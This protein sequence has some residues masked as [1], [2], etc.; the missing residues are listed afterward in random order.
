MVP[1]VAEIMLNVPVKSS[2]SRRLFAATLASLS[3]GV[4]GTQPHSTYAAPLEPNSRDLSSV[5]TAGAVADVVPVAPVEAPAEAP[6]EKARPDKSSD[7]GFTTEDFINPD[8]KKSTPQGSIIPDKTTLKVEIN[9]PQLTDAVDKFV[10]YPYAMP[11][12]KRKGNAYGPMP[13]TRRGIR[14]QIMASGYT[15]R[16]NDS[17]YYPVGG[18]RW[19]MAYKN[20]LKKSCADE[21]H[22]IMEIYPFINRLQPYVMAECKKFDKMEEERKKRVQRASEEYELNR[23]SAENEATRKGYFPIE[24][25]FLRGDRGRGAHT[26]ANLRLPDGTWYITGIHRVPGLTYYWQEPVLVSDGEIQTVELNMENALLIEGG[27]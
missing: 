27:W 4:L 21:P 8:S 13:E 15:S 5:A 20:A 17:R 3:F 23:A 19:K 2:F 22:V 16:N 14:D 24:F 6:A 26:I 18:W 12:P 11:M 25:R 9:V 7:Q 10:A 1:L